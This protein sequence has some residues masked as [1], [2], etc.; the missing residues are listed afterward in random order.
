MTKIYVVIPSYEPDDRIIELCKDLKKNNLTNVLIINDGSGPKYDYIFQK[1]EDD[2][3]Y[4]IIKHVV[5]LGKGRA[6]KTAFNYLL[7][8]QSIS[9]CVT[10]DSDGQHKVSDIKK[11]IKEFQKNQKCLILGVRDF[12][13]DNVPRKSKMG[14][15]ITKRIFKLFCGLKISDTQTG[16]RVIPADYMK[17]LITVNGERFEFETNMLLE[18]KGRYPIKEVKIETIYDS[19]ENHSTHFN[20]IVDSFKIYKN[21]FKVFVKYIFSSVSSFILDILLFTLFVSIFKENKDYIAIAT[22]LARVVSSMYNYLINYKFVF[23]SNNSKKSTLIKY[24][25]LVI[26][27]MIL[28]AT[29]VTL[30]VDLLKI[31]ETIVKIV[32]DSILFFLSFFVQRLFIFKNRK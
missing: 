25:S 21:I 29:F 9:G 19:K 11:C 32:V 16:L 30:F 17:E 18:N 28:S 15:N 13:G 31:N 22:I 23:K 14:N 12:S 24:F 26:F 2:F 20:P 5:N 7:S 27:Q 3:N 1:I 6:L 8:T 4:K 10:V